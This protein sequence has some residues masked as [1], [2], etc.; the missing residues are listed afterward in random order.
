MFIMNKVLFTFLA[1]ILFT[2]W[3]AAGVAQ[4]TITFAGID[5]YVRNGTGG[6]G[7]NHWSSSSNNVWVDANGYLHLKIRKAGGIWYC[8]EVFAQQSFGH[9][10]YRFY[11]ASN[12]EN[13]DRNLVVG[14]FTYLDIDGDGLIESS[15][16][17]G[18]IDIEFSRW[19]NASNVAGWYTVQPPPYTSSNQQSFALNLTGDYSTHKFIWSDS[20]IFFQSYHGHY[21]TLPS[22]SYLIKEWTYTGSSNPQAGSELLHINFW[23]FNGNQPTNHLD[24]ELIIRA[25]HIPDKTLNLKLFL[26]GLYAGNNTMN[27]AADGTGLPRWGAAIADKLTIELHDG[28]N[29]STVVYTA[30]DV[31]LHTDGTATVTLPVSL[32]GNYYVTVGNRNHL[33]TTTALPLSFGSPVVSYNFNIPAKA[34]GYNMLIKTD[35]T[36]VIYSGDENQDGLVDGSDLSEIAN[37]ADLASTG[38]IPEDLTGDGIVDGSD[39]S[40][41]GNDAALAI[42][43]MTP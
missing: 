37:Q 23:L 1:S 8:S 35:G 9:G 30:S 42:G 4:N 19:N 43:A 24:A 41:A 39:L 26:E 33:L 34:F 27:P 15:A 10:E 32:S 20:A 29:Y 5:W 25:V 22:Q 28:S 12:V 2:L 13:Y 21:D 36:S 6:P 16:G 7:P 17:D 11:V 18:E 31:L 40:V 3:S 14:L 38:Y